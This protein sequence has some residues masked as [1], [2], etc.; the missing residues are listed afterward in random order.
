MK[1]R[2]LAA[3]AISALLPAQE[4]GKPQFEV[5]SIK[6]NHSGDMRVGIAMEPGGRFV[7]TNVPVKML[8]LMA[9]QL[10]DN[11]L[12][13]LPGWADSDRFDIIA[14]P[15]SGSGIKSDDE[16]AMMQ[17]LLAE[18]FKLTF[19][20]DTKELPI[21]ALVVAK[22]GLKMEPSKG[23]P[24]FGDDTRTRSA[25]EPGRGPGRGRGGQGIRMMR[26]EINGANVTVG[27]LAD[28]LSRI[29]G[30]SVIDKTGLVGSYDFALKYTPEGT[31]PAGP[32]DADNHE[33]APSDS[34]RPSI[35]VAVQEQLGL[36]LES[37]KGPV[38]LY[39]I[40]HLEKP[41]EN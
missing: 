40:D 16:R 7:A 27:M 5:A 36:K 10:K 34:E 19:H 14:K 3:A 39:L 28:Q 2:I 32:K 21:Y 20:K 41:S 11:Q 22:S 23:N 38:D 31:M 15:E 12:S 17:A 33:T 6:P 25:P 4:V 29:T 8:I 13:G 9:Y 30:R 18:R 24:D 37:Q 35:F 1:F 26:G